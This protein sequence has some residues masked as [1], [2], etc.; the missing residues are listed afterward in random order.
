MNSHGCCKAR[1]IPKILHEPKAVD[2][3]ERSFLSHSH[4]GS[5]VI[6]VVFRYLI[7]FSDEG[8][9]VLLTWWHIDLTCCY[10]I[11]STFYRAEESSLANSPEHISQPKG[12]VCTYNE[13]QSF[14]QSADRERTRTVGFVLVI[15][16][17]CAT[18][19]KAPATKSHGNLGMPHLYQTGE[20]GEW[21][22]LTHFRY[23]P[24]QSL[25]AHSRLG[26]VSRQFAPW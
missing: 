22:V 24:F 19:A 23:F 1:A 8:A 21:V 3:W 13:I 15:P 4:D 17:C 11:H 12:W 5:W 2:R 20:M 25:T 16:S 18:E 10:S 26:R 9:C 6:K 14:P 7:K